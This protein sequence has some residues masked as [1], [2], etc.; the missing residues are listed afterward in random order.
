MYFID[1][2]INTSTLITQVIC[3]QSLLVISPP[4]CVVC[5]TDPHHCVLSVLLT[6]PEPN[7]WL[8]SASSADELLLHSRGHD[9]D[10]TQ[11]RA[12]SQAAH[13][14]PELLPSH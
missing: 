4:L 1:Y 11:I 12:Q 14:R 9:E 10:Q 8:R 7:L 5:A 6:D 13:V 2:L 3:G